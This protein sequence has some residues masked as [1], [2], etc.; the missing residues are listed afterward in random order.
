MVHEGWIVV[1]LMAQKTMQIW[2]NNPQQSASSNSNNLDSNPAVGM[3]PSSKPTGAGSVSNGDDEKNSTGQQPS[4]TQGFPYKLDDGRTIMLYVC[5]WCGKV[6]ENQEQ[7]KHHKTAQCTEREKYIR[8]ALFACPFCAEH[9]LEKP[10]MFAHLNSHH[11][12]LVIPDW[13]SHSKRAEKTYFKTSL[14]IPLIN[15]HLFLLFWFVLF[16]RGYNISCVLIQYFII[17]YFS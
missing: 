16:H 2:T 17:H 11:K 12:W 7:L 14:T 1:I 4:G 10:D 13:Q 6:A 15:L 5:S 9:F 3:K 8:K